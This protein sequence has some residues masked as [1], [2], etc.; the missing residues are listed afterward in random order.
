MII[1]IGIDI[2]NLTRISN[3][4]KRYDKKFINRIYGKKEIQALQNKFKN[5]DNY[6]GKD[7]LLRK[8]LGRL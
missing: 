8:Q 7:L 4:I 6:F 3:I 2:L 5:P 1:G